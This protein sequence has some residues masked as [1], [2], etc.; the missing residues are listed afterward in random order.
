MNHVACRENLRKELSEGSE[1]LENGNKA[2]KE[3]ND[4]EDYDEP[5]TNG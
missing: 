5:K 1:K 2:K 3:E 4:T